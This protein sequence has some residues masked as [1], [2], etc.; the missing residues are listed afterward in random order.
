MRISRPLHA[1]VVTAP[2]PRSDGAVGGQTGALAVDTRP[3]EPR[4][5]GTIHL[6]SRDRLGRDMISAASG[7]VASGGAVWVVSDEL[8]E[9]ARVGDPQAA[10]WQGALV[11]ALAAQQK[12]HDLEAI[13]TITPALAGTTGPALLAVASGSA[14]GRFQGVLQEL[15]ERGAAAGRG[16][17]VDLGPL[18]NA[19]DEL[20][21]LQPNIEGVT[22]R[23]TAAGT[24]LLF[25]HRGKEAGDVNKVFVLD[26]GTAF[27]AI[28]RGEALPPTSIR[29]QHAVDL[30]SLDGE[31]L[32]FA[33]AHALADGRIAFVASAEGNDGSGDGAIR[34]S[35]LGMLDADFAVQVL[36]PLTGKPR[37]VEGLERTAAFDP[38]ASP[39]C[40]TLVTDPDDPKLGTEVLT[41]DLA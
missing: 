41:V 11:P 26:A 7:L 18:Y 6:S 24:E 16:R 39:T 1:H 31:R 3:L 25:F 14:A 20:L 15:D 17:A 30:G 36:R 32:G 37:K 2:I 10:K 19:F 13:T 5:H 4:V 40:F 28:R 21:P 12:K 33:D 38:A 9:L 34:G 22:T 27:A 8:G 23:T 35:V 29:S